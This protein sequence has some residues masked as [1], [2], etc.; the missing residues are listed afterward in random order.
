MTRIISFARNNWLT[1]L[2]VGSLLGA[3]LLLRTHPSD[4]GTSAE[5][6]AIL[7]NGQPA[8]LEFYSNA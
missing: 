7:T 4:V 6:K 3:F 1:L 2:I 8:L 5:L